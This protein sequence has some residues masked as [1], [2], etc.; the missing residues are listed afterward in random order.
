MRCETCEFVNKA[1]KQATLS[2]R[3]AHDSSNGHETLANHITNFA[4][5]ATVSIKIHISLVLKYYLFD[6][7]KNSPI[8]IISRLRVFFKKL[9]IGNRVSIRQRKGAN[10]DSSL[11][12][13][14]R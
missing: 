13:D 7:L 4:T 1:C 8:I 12:D 2:Q 5:I 9:I 6:S 10:M 11:N 14:G 3:F